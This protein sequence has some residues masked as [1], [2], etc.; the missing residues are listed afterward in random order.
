MPTGTVAHG[1]LYVYER[2]RISSLPIMI[3]GRAEMAIAAKVAERSAL[4]AQ[5]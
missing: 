4:F 3:S 5:R 1:H 2:G